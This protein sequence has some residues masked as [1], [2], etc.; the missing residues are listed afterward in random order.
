MM[1]SESLHRCAVVTA[2]LALGCIAFVTLS[3]I[4]LRPA[5]TSDP[6]YERFVAYACVGLLFDMAYPR[7]LSLAVLIVLIAAI[8]LEV[9]QTFTPDRHGHVLDLFEKAA[10]GLFGII[11]S[12]AVRRCRKIFVDRPG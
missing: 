10:G 12:E 8:V 5:I 3:P 4:E 6:A 7:R 9:L 1:T 11:A 2:W